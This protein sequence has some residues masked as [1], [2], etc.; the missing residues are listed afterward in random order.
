MTSIF[1]NI[2][3]QIKHIM[4]KCQP[5]EDRGSETQPQV[6]V[7]LNKLSL[8]VLLIGCLTEPGL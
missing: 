5:L 6:V 8:K 4:S 1:A 7:H 2:C 3:A